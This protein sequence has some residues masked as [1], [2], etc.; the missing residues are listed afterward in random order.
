M[1]GGKPLIG[2]VTCAK[3]RPRVTTIL[4]TW[5]RDCKWDIVFF[6]GAPAERAGEVTLD[7][8]DDR[9]HLPQKVRAAAKWALDHGYTHMLRMDDDVYC[10]PERLVIPKADYAGRVRGG[11]GPIHPANYCSG[12]AYWMSELAM[13]TLVAAPH[14]NSHDEDVCMGNIMHKAGIKPLMLNDQ[15]VVVRSKNNWTSSLEGPRQ[16]N[17]VAISCEFQ[18]PEEMATEHNAF[19]TEKLTVIPPRPTPEKTFQRIDILIKTI[20]RDGFLIRTMSSIQKHLPGARMVIVDDGRPNHIKNHHYKLAAAAGHRIVTTPYDSGFG[21]KSNAALDHYNREFVL[22]GSDDFQFDEKAA[23]GVRKMVAAADAL[24]DFDIISGRCDAK[25]YEFYL[26]DLDPSR[27]THIHEVR[28][29]GLITDP[30][31]IQY[32]NCDLSVN[33]NLIRREVLGRE[34]GK[35]SWDDDIKIGGGE[36]AAQYIKAKRLG[37]KVCCLPDVSI[38]QQRY[39]EGCQDAIYGSL[40]GRAKKDGRPALKRLGIDSYHCYGAPKPEIA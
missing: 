4:E 17:Q 40:R 22:I 9:Q 15:F 21:A 24:P 7:V 3:F 16:F 33:Y 14:Y 32:I 34:K 29:D 38:S 8:L 37:L 31:G 10:R 11:L 26:M 13:R 18:T 25:P 12:F 19:L 36:H 30:S 35:L 2:I 23:E 5:A 20:H 1:T 6:L 27:P 39:F 28:A